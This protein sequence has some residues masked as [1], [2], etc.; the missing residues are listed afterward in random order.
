MLENEDTDLVD[1]HNNSCGTPRHKR[2]AARVRRKVAIFSVKVICLRNPILLHATQETADFA[3]V[4]D[5]VMK[6]E[7][8][9]QHS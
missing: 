6:I 8:Q 4:G 9:Q 3:A 1:R 2:V 5:S 7:T